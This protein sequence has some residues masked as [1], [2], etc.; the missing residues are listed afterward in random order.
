MIHQTGAKHI[1]I[2][3]QESGSVLH[4]LRDLHTYR[5]FAFFNAYYM[6]V[7]YSVADIV[8]TR[9]GSGTLFEIAMWGI[10]AIIIPIREEV[11]HDQRSNAYAYARATGNTVIEEQNLVPNLLIDQIDNI[12]KSS[13][14][15]KEIVKQSKKISS[16][17]AA[18]KIARLLVDV[19]KTH[20]S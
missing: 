7:A 18:K 9:A 17:D 1:D 10:P 19:L 5:P 12:Y 14:K 20:E 2:V 3:T 11:S 15:R 13:K 16:P 4:N 6:R 8:I